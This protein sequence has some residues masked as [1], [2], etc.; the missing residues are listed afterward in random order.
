[1]AWR[2]Q[3]RTVTITIDGQ[4]RVLVGASFRG[5]PFLV[6]T[7][8]RSGGRRVVVHE[9]PLRDAPFIEDLGRKAVGYR[10]DGYVLGSDYLTQMNELL[11]ALDGVEGPGELVLPYFPV[12]RA[13]CTVNGTRQTKNDGGIAM[14]S[15]E[16]SETP[17]QA[18]VPTIV[19]DSSAQVSTGADAAIEATSAE[20]TE[21][22]DASGMP[23]FALESA[24]TA[25][26]NAADALDEKLGPLIEDTQE[27]A[28][29]T[30]KIEILT[31]EAASLVRSPADALSSFH[32][33]IVGLANTIEAAPF[34]V[35]DAL[36]D[37][38]SVDLGAEVVA[39]TSTRARELANQA[40]LT[41]ALRR[42]IAIEAARIAPTVPYA[43]IDDAIAARDAVGALLDEQAL[44]AGDTAYPAIVNL[45][46]N[47]RRNV[48]G[49]NAFASV[50]T[51][52]QRVP[53][54]SLVIAHRLYGSVDLEPDIV[55][56]NGI[57]HPGF[58]VG[59]LKV[60]SDG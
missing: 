34:A 43:T 22:F 25:L 60:L 9:F 3:L 17:L 11:D 7:V 55:A 1:M 30:G 46:S 45:A 39:T 28:E 58:C 14:V 26:E 27:L 47:V 2:D 44:G 21:K 10:V 12:L 37:A 49:G 18:P 23:A 35:L 16:F 41:G 4:Q 38:Y 6:D 56:R 50:S 32:D 24:Q 20:L 54:P 33:A 53:L 52:E 40:A 31:S 36:I 51:I 42:V 57:R 59:T 13:I 48:P 29:F 8:E 5:V 19:V 15:L